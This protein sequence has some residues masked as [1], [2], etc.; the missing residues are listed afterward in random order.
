MYGIMGGVLWTNL[1]GASCL[2]PKR[3]IYQELRC[4]T[5][6]KAFTVTRKCSKGQRCANPEDLHSVSAT[7]D[8]EKSHHNGFDSHV[9]CTCTEVW[10]FRLSGRGIHVSL[11]SSIL[12][13]WRFIRLRNTTSPAC[14]TVSS[15]H[16]HNGN[17]L[18]LKPSGQWSTLWKSR[19]FP[20]LFERDACQCLWAR[21]TR[22]KPSF[23]RVHH[24]GAGHWKLSTCGHPANT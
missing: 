4:K 10:N 20:I 18:R 12:M 13:K 8:A 23:F 21:K 22:T 1:S 5:E 14:V 17:L 9:Q 11:I 6:R 19:G 3:S 15:Q 24:R 2:K 7:D 16:S